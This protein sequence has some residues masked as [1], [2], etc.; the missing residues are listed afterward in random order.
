MAT[1]YKTMLFFSKHFRLIVLTGAALFFPSIAISSADKFDCSSF[2]KI[3]FVSNAEREVLPLADYVKKHIKELLSYSSVD[4]KLHFR[5]TSFSLNERTQNVGS[6]AQMG[7]YSHQIVFKKVRESNPQVLYLDS[8]Y[9]RVWLD[10]NKNLN[11]EIISA[12]SG[13]V[14]QD[15]TITEYFS[16]EI[17][18]GLQE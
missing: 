11:I 1:G 6:G 14:L 16:K 2:L 9:G 10:P 5:I 7:S 13:L 15:P 4:S 12:S 17:R 18:I 8:F 3:P